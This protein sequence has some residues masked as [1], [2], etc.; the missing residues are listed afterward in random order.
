VYLFNLKVLRRMG[1][2]F[3]VLENSAGEKS[4]AEF[5]GATPDKRREAGIEPAPLLLAALYR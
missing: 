1:G 2:S 5:C 3:L 4:D